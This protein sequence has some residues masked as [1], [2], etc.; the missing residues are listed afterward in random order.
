MEE[1]VRRLLSRLWLLQ[2][3]VFA[4]LGYV[5]TLSGEYERD[6]GIACAVG[7]L[8]LVSWRDRSSRVL[9]KVT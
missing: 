8:D 5:P 9:P 4:L 7:N 2:A 3:A 1:S 6:T